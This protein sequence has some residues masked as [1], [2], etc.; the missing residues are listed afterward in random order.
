MLFLKER[1][2]KHV[3]HQLLHQITLQQKQK[4]VKK[5]FNTGISQKAYIN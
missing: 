4:Q 3:I 2:K 1:G 5:S